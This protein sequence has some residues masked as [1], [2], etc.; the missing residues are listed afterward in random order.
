MD[1]Y[2]LF[3]DSAADIPQ[4]YY[5]E[6]DIRIIPM[7][8]LFNGESRTFHTEAPDRE[9]VCDEVYQAMREGADVHTSQITP[10]RYIESWTP[11]LEE[12]HDILCLSFIKS[13]LF[14]N[15]FLKYWLLFISF[16][17]GRNPLWLSISAGKSVTRISDKCC[18]VR[19]SLRSIC[20]NFSSLII[21]RLLIY[22]FFC[23]LA[24]FV[25]FFSIFF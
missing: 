12:G 5:D 6:F 2:L 20:W 13:W 4:H 8:Y 17:S 21:N 11:L 9:H 3:T 1:S 22:R 16:I 19:H 7:D 15:R 14:I 18:L 10:Y 23:I 25:A 24:F